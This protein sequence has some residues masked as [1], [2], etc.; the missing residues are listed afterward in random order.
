MFFSLLKQAYPLLPFGLVVPLFL[1]FQEI[2]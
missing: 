1:E 2:L